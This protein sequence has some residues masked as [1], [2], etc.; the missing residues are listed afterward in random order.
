MRNAS[1]VKGLINN[2]IQLKTMTPLKLI[3]GQNYFNL[4]WFLIPFLFGIYYYNTGIILGFRLDLK[5]TVTYSTMF[6]LQ[7]KALLF[8]H[9]SVAAT[10]CT[11]SLQVLIP[12]EK[13][14]G[15]H[16]SQPDKED[17]D[18]VS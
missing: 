15:K 16:T 4:V 9:N 6:S 8:E 10:W 14:E 1:G 12:E 17:A 2:I 3:S 13:T 7:T 11:Y 5:F 18:K